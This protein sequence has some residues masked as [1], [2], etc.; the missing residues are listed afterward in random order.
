MLFNSYWHLADG[1]KLITFNKLARSLH[2]CS[3][4]LFKS[5]KLPLARK[6]IYASS[7]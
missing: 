7:A 5:F 2:W 6:I 4:H 1:D 3:Y